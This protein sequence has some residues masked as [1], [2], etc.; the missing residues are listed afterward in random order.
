MHLIDCKLEVLV[1]KGDILCM[2][3]K[4]HNFI[5]QLNIDR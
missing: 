5:C 3:L 2:H 1:H 4:E